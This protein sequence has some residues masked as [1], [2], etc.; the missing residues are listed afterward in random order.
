MYSRLGYSSSVMNRNEFVVNA[1]ISQALL[2]GKLILKLEGRDIFNQ[3]SA[4][5][6]EVNA[7]GRTESWHR[8]LPSYIMLHAVY[9][10]NREPKH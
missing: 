7:Q 1:N 6:Y 8:I 2:H 10:F 4:T 3:Q 9:H 5:S